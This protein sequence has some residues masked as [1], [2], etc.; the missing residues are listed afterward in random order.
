MYEDA[1]PDDLH[2]LLTIHDSLLWQRRPEHDTKDLIHAIENVAQQLE[3][4]VP[5]PFGLGSGRHWA[6][7]SYGSKLEYD[8]MD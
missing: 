5:I 6:E 2:I 1:Y 7:A 4:N 3:L 8:D